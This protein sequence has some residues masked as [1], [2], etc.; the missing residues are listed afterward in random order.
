[1]LGISTY[2]GTNEAVQKL[3]SAHN[4]ELETKVADVHSTFWDEEDDFLAGAAEEAGAAALEGAGV[5]SFFV[6]GVMAAVVVRFE[7]WRW[8]RGSGVEDVV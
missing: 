5:D 3:N 2:I 6:L 4:H 8:F 1:M 7:L